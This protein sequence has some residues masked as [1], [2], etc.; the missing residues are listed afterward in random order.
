MRLVLLNLTSFLDADDW[1]ETFVV[2]CCSSS[3]RFTLLPNKGFPV[4]RTPIV[5]NL[6]L[7]GFKGPRSWICRVR[8]L[9]NYFHNHQFGSTGMHPLKMLLLHSF[10][11]VKWI[12]VATARPSTRPVRLV[13]IVSSFGH[14]FGTSVGSYA[15]KERPKLVLLQFGLWLFLVAATLYGAACGLATVSQAMIALN[16]WRQGSCIDDGLGHVVSITNHVSLV[17]R[18]VMTRDLREVIDRCSMLSVFP[19]V[20]ELI[21]LAWKFISCNELSRCGRI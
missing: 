11:V 15:T 16:S 20:F 10:S 14:A 1:F 2:N 7:V 9:W 3:D 18:V 13:Q 6:S 17:V 8:S 19:Q 12:V 5:I 4:N 21:V